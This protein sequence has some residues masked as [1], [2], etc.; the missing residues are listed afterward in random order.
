MAWGHWDGLADRV[1]AEV[2][3]EDRKNCEGQNSGVKSLS[4]LQKVYRWKNSHNI[5]NSFVKV[6]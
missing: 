1:T 2:L 5:L 3:R 6:G 4:K